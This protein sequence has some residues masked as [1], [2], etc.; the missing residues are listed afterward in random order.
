MFVNN[1]VDSRRTLRL[2]VLLGALALG[3]APAQAA[4]DLFLNWPGVPGTSTNPNHLREIELLSYS[5]TASNIPVSSPGRGKTTTTTSTPICGQITIMKRVD[6][7]SPIILGMVL[8]GTVTTAPVVFTFAKAGVQNDPTFYSVTLQNVVPI[9]IT[10][11]DSLGDDT[12]AE[13]V[14]LMASQFVFTY[15]PLDSTGKPIGNPVSFGWDCTTNTRT[16]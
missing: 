14:V 16:Q 11:S 6:Q 3:S 8:A 13:T 5:Q 15:T 2:A 9:S 7:A 12:P 10:Q 4:V 1:S